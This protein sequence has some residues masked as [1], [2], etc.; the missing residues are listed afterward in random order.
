M[1]SLAI[2]PI[3]DADAQPCGRILFEAF[4]RFHDHHR[5]PPDFQSLEEAVQLAELFIGHPAIFG[6]VAEMD[7][8]I[9]GSNFLDERND[10]RG[11]GPITVDTDVQ[12]QGVGRRLMDDVIFR[13]RDAAGI[14]LVQDGFN[15][16]SLSLYASLGFRPREPLVLL[17]GRPQEAPPP[18]V[19]VRPL[20][21]EDLEGCAALCRR[22][23]GFDRSRELRDAMALFS[24]V[25][26]RRA[27]EVTAY[28]SAPSYWKLNHGVAESDWHMQ[29]L[30]LGAARLTAQPL[31]MLL[32]VRHPGF[33]QWCLGQGFRA[34]KPM[35]LMTMGRY[36]DAVGCGFP[37]VLY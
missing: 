7:G 26:V 10:M 13:G 8:R 27:G 29:A 4:R 3:T 1:S 35:T 31:S 28:A 14:R 2:R 36:Q 30:L 20:R 33:L 25:V 11:V 37:S 23:H 12:G 21:E 18:E 16:R 15:M 34:V 5:F 6:V 22:V 17:T 19:E 32:P 24:P 9:V